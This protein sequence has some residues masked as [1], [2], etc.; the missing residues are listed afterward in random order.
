MRVA[1]SDNVRPNQATSFTR[2]AVLQ[3]IHYFRACDVS[4]QIAVIET[5][6]EYIRAH[7]AIKLVVIDSIAFHFR[8]VRIVVT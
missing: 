1:G 6:E 4:E 8:Q 7:P 3:G 2:D 5:L